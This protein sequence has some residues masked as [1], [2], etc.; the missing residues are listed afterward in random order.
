MEQAVE[1]IMFWHV[2]HL[3]FIGILG[4]L[5]VAMGAGCARYEPKPLTRE[6]IDQVLAPNCGGD[7]PG[8]LSPDQIAV[9]AV[10]M[11]LE[12][13]AERDRRALSNAQ[14]LQAGLLPN[15][16]LTGGFDQPIGGT[17]HITGYSIGANWDITS[18]IA[19]KERKEAARADA[20]SVELDIAWKEW[21]TAEAA[22]MAA[23]DVAALTAQL[24]QLDKIEQ[25]LV[26]NRDLLRRA[27]ET[28]QKTL[29]DLAASEAAAS[30]AHQSVVVT[31]GELRRAAIAPESRHRLAA[32]SDLAGQ[33]GP[34]AR[35]SLAT[36]DIS[37]SWILKHGDLICSR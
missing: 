1:R 5:C 20:A 25:E 3:L 34:T 33:S 2:R 17:D 18:L 24:S 9:L 16:Q 23:Y 36:R 6:S 26:A 37:C 15:P 27:V 32:G 12:L 10:K 19:R 31:T 11:N 29:T 14:V 28:N 35:R 21:Q 30:D 22:K 7:L 13:R 4:F 8:S